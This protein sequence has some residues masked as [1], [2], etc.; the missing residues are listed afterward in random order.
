MFNR[1]ATEEELDRYVGEGGVW[2]GGATDLDSARDLI[3]A[4]NTP[5]GGDWKYDEDGSGLTHT[6]SGF[7]EDFDWDEH[8]RKLSEENGEPIS[9]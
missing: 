7:P 5:S 2:G 4:A 6:G 1:D 8:W 9:I 3:S